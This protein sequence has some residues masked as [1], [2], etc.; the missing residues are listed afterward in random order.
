MDKFKLIQAN[1]QRKV[2]SYNELFIV[3]TENK[4]REMLSIDGGETLP[5]ITDIHAA[6]DK[7]LDE[8]KYYLIVL[9]PKKQHIQNNIINII[10]K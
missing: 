3:Y 1:A 2:Y 10:S 8:L 7:L 5:T 6:R 9:P 4:G